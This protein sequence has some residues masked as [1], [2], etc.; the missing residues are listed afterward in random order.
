VARV[1]SDARGDKI[2]RQFQAEHVDT[3]YITRDQS[4]PTG[5]SLI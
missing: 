3:C 5:I 2:V 1:G 4:L